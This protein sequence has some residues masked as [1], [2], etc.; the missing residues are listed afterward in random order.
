MEC[1]TGTGTERQ[2]D[3]GV[4]RYGSNISIIQRMIKEQGDISQT[5]SEFDDLC[6][7]NW[8]AIVEDYTARNITEHPDRLIAIAGI[9]QELQK[10]T[11][12]Q[13][14]AGLWRH[15][16]FSHLCWYIRK[17]IEDG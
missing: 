16:R 13:Y 4:A 2:L 3:G 5:E 11:G 15:N 10:R 7:M 12:N 6:G 8:Q 1:L 17:Q 9:A 14:L